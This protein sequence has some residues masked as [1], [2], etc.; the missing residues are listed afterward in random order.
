MRRRLAAGAVLVAL[1]SF[2]FASPLLCVAGAVLLAS[3][4]VAF[5]ELRS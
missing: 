2:G 5:P 3:I 1:V 4:W